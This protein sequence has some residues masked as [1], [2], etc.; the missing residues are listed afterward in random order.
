MELNRRDRSLVHSVRAAE[1]GLRSTSLGRVQSAGSD[2]PLLCTGAWPQMAA[3][4]LIAGLQINF[5]KYMNLQIGNL[6]IM[7][8]DCIQSPW[9]P[10]LWELSRGKWFIFCDSLEPV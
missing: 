6:K 10:L 7:R 2:R 9:K 4:M 5:S 3:M 8:T 1:R